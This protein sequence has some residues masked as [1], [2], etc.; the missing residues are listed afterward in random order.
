MR[1]LK[2]AYIYQKRIHFKA[3]PERNIT[4][5]LNCW[6][7]YLVV[8]TIR[9]LKRQIAIVFEILNMSEVNFRVE[10]ISYC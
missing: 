3:T 5:L 7:E 2:L 1:L 9:Q 4:I 10:A 6:M 8:T